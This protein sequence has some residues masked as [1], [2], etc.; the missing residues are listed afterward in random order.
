MFPLGNVWPIGDSITF[1]VGGD[2]G[3][4]GCGY[5]DV[6]YA[7]NQK[8]GASLVGT[9]SGGANFAT[10]PISSVALKS[11]G[12]SGFR[13]SSITATVGG[14]YSTIAA[15]PPRVCLIH[16]GTNDMIA[17]LA[18]TQTMLAACSEFGTMLDTIV[19]LDTSMTFFVATLLHCGMD[20]TVIPFNDNVAREVERHKR[21]GRAMYLVDMYPTLDPATDYDAGGI[22]P[23]TGG[24]AKMG[25]KWSLAIRTLQP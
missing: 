19:A 3:A 17:Y 7:Q 12:H 5:R 18:G 25:A 11:D 9:L 14:Y 6:M 24:Y 22:H 13:C 20:T 1:G 4:G 16:M 2:G 10:C 8:W 23:N 15:T 21:A